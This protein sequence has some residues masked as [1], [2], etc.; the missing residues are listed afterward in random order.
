MSRWAAA[1]R[2]AWCKPRFRSGPD[3]SGAG[4]WDIHPDLLHRVTIIATG[5]LNSLPHNGAVITRLGVFKMTHK[6]A[7]EDIFVVACVVPILALV[8]I[9]KHCKLCWIVL[10]PRSTGEH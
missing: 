10:S 9:L 1:A 3:F 8:T 5:G 7:Y 4:V 6:Q 2:R